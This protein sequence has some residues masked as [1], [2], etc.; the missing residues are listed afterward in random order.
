M[1]HDG[2]QMHRNDQILVQKI[3]GKFLHVATDRHA[4]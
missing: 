2:G 1:I 4:H 3:R